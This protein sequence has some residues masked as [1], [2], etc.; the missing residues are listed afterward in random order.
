L[1]GEHEL[2]IAR[3]CRCVGL[4]RSAF[5]RIPAHWTVRDVNVIAALVEG[6]SNRGVWKCVKLLRRNGA[7][8]NH[9][10]IYRVYRQMVLHLRRPARKR[11]PKRLR[12]PLY[13]PV[14][15][16]Q[17]WSADFVSDSLVHGKR[18]RTFNVVDDFDHEVLH[19]EIDTSIT[20]ARLVSVFKQLRAGATS[21]STYR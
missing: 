21:G 5:Y 1:V 11:L 4:S 8:W 2:S 16:D 6:L 14:F 17:V 13:V 7:P 9:K 18:F 3:A 10:K 15:P 20:S 12:V 19:I